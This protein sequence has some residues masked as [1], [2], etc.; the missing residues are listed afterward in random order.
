MVS[1][2]SQVYLILIAYFPFSSEVNQKPGGQLDLLRIETLHHSDKDKTD[3]HILD[4]VLWL[5]HLVC[6]SKSGNGGI[7]SP[8]KSPVR[9]PKQNGLTSSLA[10]TT[11]SLPCSALTQEDQEML[12]YV[13][14]RKL[15]PGISRSQEFNTSKC[16]SGKKK[17][18]SK[19]NSQSPTS[20][21][22][23]DFFT[24]KRPSLLP[25]IDFDID[26]V[27]AMDVIDRVDDIRK[28]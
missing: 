28:P 21:S 16:R 19:S 11:Q 20:C 27:K 13:N 15:T 3:T 2:M 25:V 1:S 10:S 26:R 5:H 18:L 12:L 17:R 24:T 9:S 14:A 8:V 4:L 6:H 22:K 23:N 7:K